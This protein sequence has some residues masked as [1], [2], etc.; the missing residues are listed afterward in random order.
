MNAQ[1]LWSGYDYAHAKFG[2]TKGVRYHPP[3]EV[4]RVRIVRVYKKR[5]YGNERMS[6]F[7][8]VVRCD[9]ESGDYLNGAVP[10]EISARNIFMRWDD[11]WDETERRRLEQE[12]QN[13]ERERERLARQTVEEKVKELIAKAG[14]PKPYEI[15]S[16]TVSFKRHQLV[17]YLE[18]AT[19]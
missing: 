7:A 17:E 12:R 11:Y 5:L 16:Y 6:S 14:L 18:G 1:D 8:E 15:T 9:P 13:A 2:A 4:E 10:I 19:T 3:R